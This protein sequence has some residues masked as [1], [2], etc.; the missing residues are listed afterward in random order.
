M[1]GAMETYSRTLNKFY[2]DTKALWQEDFDW[3]GF[4]WIDCNDYENSVISFIRKA[5]DTNDFIIVLCNFTPETRENYRV[6]VPSKGVYVEVFNS[7]DK[8]FGGS[9]LRNEG[10]MQSQDVPWHGRE[11][12]ITLTLPPLSTVFLRVKG[13]AGAGY[14]APELPK[15]TEVKG[16]EEKE[17]GKASTEAA[18]AKA[19][20]K[21]G[22]RKSS[23][24]AVRSA[25]ARSQAGKKTGIKA[26]VAASAE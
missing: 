14:I 19:G 26:K 10:D 1:H 9:G 24:K 20:R 3:E 18:S 5:K 21:T 16:R 13:Q 7:D 12:S 17:V 8:G 15:A 25:T 4:K 6:G 2:C 22:S 11:Q 23:P